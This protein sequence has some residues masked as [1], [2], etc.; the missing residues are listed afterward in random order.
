MAKSSKLMKSSLTEI[1]LR[2]SLLRLEHGM[3]HLHTTIADTQRKQEHG[4]AGLTQ[5]LAQGQLVVQDVQDRLQQLKDAQDQAD[6]IQGQR[7]LEQTSTISRPITE[8]SLAHQRLEVKIDKLEATTVTRVAQDFAS[9]ATQTSL[10]TSN[11]GHYS[12]HASA[13]TKAA[14][15][16]GHCQC[17]CHRYSKINTPS[18]LRQFLG[19]LFI[20]YTGFPRITSPCNSRTCIRRASPAA[21]ATY[22]F[23]NWFLARAMLLTITASFFEGPRLSLAFPRVVENGSLLFNYIEKGDIA[24][25]KM[26]FSQQ[27]ASP[28][29]MDYPGGYTALMVSSSLQEPN[30]HGRLR[31]V[32]N[33]CSGLYTS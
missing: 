4:I 10:D 2:S 5:R 33:Q 24:G 29:D 7:V 30:I 8:L 14:R 25:I 13:I 28:F 3:H 17:I 11:A 15:C 6:T 18:S 27:L 23:P 21:M 16:S 32:L 9:S 22:I 31:R 20:G 19:V 1:A 26:L 12:I